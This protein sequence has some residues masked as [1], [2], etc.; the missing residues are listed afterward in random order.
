MGARGPLSRTLWALM[1]TTATAE[2]L[3]AG[4]ADLEAAAAGLASRLPEPLHPLA[5]L[6]YNYRWSWTRGGPELFADIDRTRWGLCHGNPVRLLQEVPPTALQRLAGD[7]AFLGRMQDLHATVAAD[8][9]RPY[10]ESSVTAGRPAAFFCAEYAVHQSLPV[11]SGGLGVLAGDILKAASDLAVP[12]VGIGLMYRHGYFRQRTDAGGWQ[13]EYWVDTD[14]DRVP[15]ALITAG[16]QPL[17]VSVPVDGRHVVAQIWRVNAGRVPLLLLDTNRPENTPSDRFITSRLYVGEP[18]LRLAQYAVLGI[19]GVRALRALHIDPAV[20]HLN[21][22]HAA[23]ASLEL[24]RGEA[25]R[26]G[27]DVHDAFAAARARTVFTT[28]TPVPAGND[29]YPADHVAY[30]LAGEAAELGV[31]VGELI[32]RG[33]TN[34]EDPHEPFGV[35]QFA[36]RSSRAANGVARRHGEVARHMWQPLWRDRAV[37]DVPISHVTNGVHVP[38]W[39]GAHMWDLLD[40]HLDEGW[41][42]RVEDPAAWDGV[43]RI[44]DE[45]LWAA[46]TAQRSEMIA[47][48]RER[49]VIERLA[50]GE[51]KQHAHAAAE[52]LDDNVLTVGF[53]RRLAT[54]KRLDM[55]LRDPDRML[56]LLGAEDRPVQ[57]LVAGKAHPKDDDGKRLVTRLFEFRHHPQVAG[58]VVFLDDYDVALAATLVRGCDV[59]V[60]LPRPPLEASGTSGMKNAINGGLQLSVLDGWWPEAFD[61]GNGDAPNGWAIS[62][63]VDPDHGAQDARHAGDFYRLL[64]EEV[65]PTFYDGSPPARWLAMVRRSLARM[66]PQFSA[67]RMVSDYVE[68]MYPARP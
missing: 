10:A 21:E 34:P 8:L 62:G 9:A 2:P 7:R 4:T 27:L 6:A 25:L 46:R 57:L 63:D 15:A 20:V 26:S 67:T 44:P 42:S 41:L 12:L 65:V 16:D 29:T 52:A 31:D 5:E 30:L 37:D 1:L 59:W 3:A 23:F 54:Y 43:A 19:G 28:H 18:D 35:T 66:G 13:H 39:L 53:A 45:E 33:R 40:R 32:A 14:A 49:S 51:G 64:G 48:V 68:R 11:Y 38:T 55:L 24:A 50:R 60:N 22:G 36:L 56:G 58:R 17:T 47:M 61:A